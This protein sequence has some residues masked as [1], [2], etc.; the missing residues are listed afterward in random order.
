MWNK[1]FDSWSAKSQ[2]R[3][4]EVVAL[5]VSSAA[6]E[7]L[8]LGSYVPGLSESPHF[9]PTIDQTIER[10]REN[11]LQQSPLTGNAPVVSI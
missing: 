10:S 5:V 4:L 9:A 2:V 7:L 1:Q 11:S 8:P 3:P 6:I